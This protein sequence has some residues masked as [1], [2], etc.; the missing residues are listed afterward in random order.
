MAL[1]QNP[2]RSAQA[3]VARPLWRY[4]IVAIVVGRLQDNQDL[5]T[6]TWPMNCR[7]PGRGRSAEPRLPLG[8]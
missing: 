4:G 1:M 5:F 7:A 3:S 2:R 6:A 8:T